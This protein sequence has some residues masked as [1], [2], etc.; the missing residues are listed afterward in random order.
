MNKT[1]TVGI[2]FAVLLMLS[3]IAS[4][5]NITTTVVTL[6]GGLS[7]ITVSPDPVT[8]VFEE[9]QSFVASGHDADGNPVSITPVWSTDI[10]TIDTTGLFTAQHKP[11]TGTVTATS[12]TINGTANVTIAEVKSISVNETSVDFEAVIIGHASEPQNVTVTNTGNVD[13]TLTAAPTAL[14]SGANTIAASNV[15]QSGFGLLADL[16]SITGNF[17][18]TIPTGTP[19]GTYT[20]TIDITAS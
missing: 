15:A 3:G 6:A 18:L 11:G 4:A 19:L 12:G 16:G 5:E 14:T 1:G 8:V 17:T 10:G 20:G 2:V 9:N 7:Y 13:V